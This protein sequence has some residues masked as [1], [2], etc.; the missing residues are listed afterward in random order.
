VNVLGLTTNRGSSVELAT[1]LDKI[2]GVKK[3]ST[4]VTLITTRIVVV[5]SRA[6]TL[7][8][9]IS[10]EGAVLL[11]E[12]LLGGALTEETVIPEA[13]EDCLRDLCVLLGRGA[14]EVVKTNVEPLVHFLVDLVVL[15]AKLLR[16]HLLLQRLGFS[17]CAIFVRSANV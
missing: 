3:V 11:T 2:K 9:T 16:R 5:A 17:C 1:G 4:F 6:F 12:W 13:L 15:G 14:A 8:V 10:Q 7:N